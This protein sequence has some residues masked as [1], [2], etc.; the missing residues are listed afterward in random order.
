M[1]K[2]KHT[3]VM[4]HAKGKGRWGVRTPQVQIKFLATN[5]KTYKNAWAVLIGAQTLETLGWSAGQKV[6]F[7]YD[8]GTVRMSLQDDGRALVRLNPK[9][10]RMIVRYTIHDEQVRRLLDGQ[11][12]NWRVN[13][14]QLV[15]DIEQSAFED[16]HE[17]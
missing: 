14:H 7:E 6:G 9:Y 3:D 13:G 11:A 12:V 4:H 1:K 2:F 16:S 5:R 15:F 17:R 10:D 8:Q